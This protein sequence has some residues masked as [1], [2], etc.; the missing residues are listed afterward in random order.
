MKVR[1]DSATVV[2]FANLLQ[3]PAPSRFLSTMV[4]LRQILTEKHLVL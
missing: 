2:V 1:V 3:P 4:F